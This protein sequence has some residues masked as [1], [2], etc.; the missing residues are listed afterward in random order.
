LE[1]GSL[2][3][4]VKAGPVKGEANRAVIKALAKHFKVSRS[5]IRIVAGHRTRNKLVEIG[6]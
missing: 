2:R 5:A 3:V 1:D 6:S 4:E